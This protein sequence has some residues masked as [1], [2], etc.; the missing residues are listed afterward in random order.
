MTIATSYK[1]DLQLAAI[2]GINPQYPASPQ[3]TSLD[4]T[5]IER[6]QFGGEVAAGNM[7]Q[8]YIKTLAYYDSFVPQNQLQLLSI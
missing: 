7:Q 4:F 8:C 3:T 6:L 2:N 1:D 5:T